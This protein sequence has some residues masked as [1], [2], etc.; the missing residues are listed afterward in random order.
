M[1]ASEMSSD[2]SYSQNLHL[3]SGRSASSQIVS[4]HEPVHRIH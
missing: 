2:S 3:I 4:Q 1:T